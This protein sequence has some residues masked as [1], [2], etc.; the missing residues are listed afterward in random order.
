MYRGTAPEI[1]EKHFVPVIAGPL[2][3]DL[4]AEAAL[5]PGERVLDVA[6]GTGIVARIAAEQV[7]SKGTVS[8]LDIS[9]P[10]LDVGRSLPPPKGAEVRWYETSA[11]SIP[12]PDEQFDVVFCHLGLMF[13]SDAPAALR[14]MHRVLVPEGRVLATFPI[15]NEFFT[16]LETTLARHVPPAAG[17]VGKVFSLGDP[18]RAE[19]LFR[20]AGFR[21]IAVR[22]HTKQ[23][24]LPPPRDFLWHYVGCTPM[25]EMVAPPGDPRS[26]ALER[27]VV[28]AW[29][30]WVRNDGMRCEQSVLVATARR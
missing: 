21:D 28:E 22:P 17:F 1:Y 26:D 16:R 3:N 15:A 4:V 25:S 14:E 23:L 19:G 11:E 29:Q 12:L 8:A 5:Q 20:D 10:M 7:G 18:K 13:I 9:A 27:D 2:A 24:T 6:C 30:P